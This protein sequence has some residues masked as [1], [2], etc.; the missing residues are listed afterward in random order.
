MILLSQAAAA[1][2]TTW[3]PTKLA[4]GITL[5]NNNLTANGGPSSGWVS[6]YSINPKGSGKRYVEVAGAPASNWACGFSYNT[7][8][9]GTYVGSDANSIGVFYS[10]GNV[11]IN[12]VGSTIPSSVGPSNVVGMAIDLDGR[13]LWVTA[14]GTTWNNGGGAS[15]GG[16]GGISFSTVPLPLMIAWSIAFVSSATLQLQS[17][18]YS[19]PT[20]F[21]PWDS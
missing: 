7:A 21:V 11:Y 19:L 17:F 13:L 16:T 18:T 5:S 12:N 8:T 14:T 15:P 4:A 3:D 10:Q 6:S 20:S 9:I 1:P 2:T